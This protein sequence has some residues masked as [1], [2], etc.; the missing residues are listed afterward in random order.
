LRFK[1]AV[2]LD[3]SHIVLDA[4]SF[5]PAPMQPPFP[6]AVSSATLL[7]DATCSEDCLY[8][9]VWT[10]VEPGPHPVFVWIYGGGNISGATSE[11]I[12]DGSNFARSGVVCVTVGYRVG[13][14]GFLELG[15]LLGG[16][17]RGSGNN[18]IRDQILGLQWVRE[19]IGALGGDPSR[20]T[21]GGESAGAKSVSALLATPSARGLFQSAIIESGG[22]QTVH[23]VEEAKTVTELFMREL[24]SINSASDALFVASATEL[25][26]IEQ[27]T[28]AAYPRS[29]AFRAVVDG[30]TLPDQPLRAVATG[31]S[32]DVRVL[33]GSNR[34]ESL[35]FL[36]RALADLHRADKA[37]SLPISSHELAQLDVQT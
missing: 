2:P 1:P 14:F 18:A 27:R 15:E 30:Q 11:P 23:A 37:A 36:P 13:A 12:Y 3:P 5:A 29:F 10:P 17:F 6:V 34:D 33:I 9:N 8:L 4:F 26:T 22:G 21:V 19:N 32:R 35:L 7:G 16:K 31:A 24:R 20:V 25:L 28:I